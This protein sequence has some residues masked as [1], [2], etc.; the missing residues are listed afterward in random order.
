FPVSNAKVRGLAQEI[1]AEDKAR[2]YLMIIK[3]A[4]DFIAREGSALAHR[5]RETKPA[6][7]CALCSLRKNEKLFHVTQAF[8]K[9]LK[10]TP[11]LFDE[12]RQLLK[13]RDTY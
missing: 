3:V 13:L 10:I 8:V 1:A 2:R 5:K 11:T 7:L 4:Q 6:R 9:K 12:C